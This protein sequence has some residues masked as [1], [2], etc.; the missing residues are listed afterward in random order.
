ME[1]H[2]PTAVFSENCASVLDAFL[3][4]LVQSYIDN[5]VIKHCE[6]IEDG[7]SAYMHDLHVVETEFY[8]RTCL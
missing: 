5:A 1:P 2:P 4:V 8:G 3:F 6:E 7:R